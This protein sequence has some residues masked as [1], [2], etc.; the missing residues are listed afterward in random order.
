MVDSL[1]KKPILLTGATGFIGS[2]LYPLLR[3]EGYAVRC[4]TRSP[5]RAR[6]NHPLRDW[7]KFDVHQPDMVRSALEGCGAVFYLIHEMS[8]GEGYSDREKHAAE[9]V[10]GAAE[11]TGV[12]RLIYLGGIEPETE[13]SQHL[14][15]RLRTGR[16]LRGG[17][18]SA[19]ELRA[20]MIIGKGSASWQIVRDLAARLPIM[21]LPSW[22]KSRTQPVHVSDVLEALRGALTLDTVENDYQD[23][24][25]PETL[26]VEAI[27]RRTARLLDN[28]PLNIRVPLLTPRLSSYWLKFVTRSNYQV[29]REL[30]EGLRSDILADDDAYWERI[31][32]ENLVSFDDAVRRS[33]Q[34]DVES[35]WTRLYENGVKTLTQSR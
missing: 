1:K 21:L 19:V 20:S 32:H 10:L 23:L 8:A 34:S 2:S 7:V 22:T 27:L 6:K 15:S 14:S 29:A 25:G 4:A 24:P 11:E 17:S 12:D 28:N 13:P 16:I 18:V 31:G 5:E 33:L 3:N 35:L 30:V 26:S 9:N